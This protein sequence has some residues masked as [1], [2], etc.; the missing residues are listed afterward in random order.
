V[1][2]SER[3]RTIVRENLNSF[4]GDA[5]G[6]LSFDP[7]K[8]ELSAHDFLEFAE[9]ELG[10]DTDYNRINCISHLK[11]ALDCSLDTF[12]HVFNLFDLWKRNLKFEKKLELLSAIGVFSSRSLAR[13]NTIRNRMEHDYEI[14]KIAD[15]EVYFDLVSAV[16]SVLERVAIQ[17]SEVSF[18]LDGHT[19]SNGYFSIKYERKVPRI[20]ASRQT[21][22][23][24]EELVAEAKTEI[25]EFAF[26]FKVLILLSQRWVNIGSD[27]YLISQISK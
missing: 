19:R 16:V 2:K 27:S 17:H 1:S 3:L 6:F 7:P 10:N 12:L 24:I 4:E 26:F 22:S 5:G 25:D 15:I 11:R 18:S 21:G 23:N 13:L 8:F 14:P 9:K 20:E